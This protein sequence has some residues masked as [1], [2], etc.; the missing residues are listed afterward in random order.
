MRKTPRT[1][2]GP[3]DVEDTALLA[4]CPRATDKRSYDP[5]ALMEATEQMPRRQ[6]R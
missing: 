6:G 2:G 4:G 1:D 5:R 3:R